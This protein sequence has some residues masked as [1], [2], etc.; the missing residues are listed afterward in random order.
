MSD[1]ASIGNEIANGNGHASAA[2]EILGMADEKI[3]E[4]VSPR[5]RIIGVLKMLIA[6][7]LAAMKPGAEQVGT[8][9]NTAKGLFEQVGG[10]Y[11]AAFGGSSNPNARVALGGMAEAA[12]SLE[13]RQQAF[14]AGE[15]LQRQKL[16]AAIGAAV[17]E[18]R[19][20]AALWNEAA[21]TGVREGTETG[22]AAVDAAKRYAQDI[23]C[24]LPEQGLFGPQT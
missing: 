20:Y 10:Q 7:D 18:A 12:K 1:I 9:M 16:E 15:Q 17:V 2:L 6:E 13:T 24:E 23:G 22:Q 3:K 8:Q 21:A 11:E 5:H 14:S 4:G 19:A